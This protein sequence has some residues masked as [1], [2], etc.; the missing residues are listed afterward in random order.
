M[1]KMQTNYMIRP[2]LKFVWP[3]VK[4]RIQAHAHHREF[5]DHVTHARSIY[6]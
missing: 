3:Y 2:T 5:I 4:R 6:V 1:Q